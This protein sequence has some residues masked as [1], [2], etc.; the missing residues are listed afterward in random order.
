MSIRETIAGIELVDNH[1]HPVEELS[2]E[3]ITREFPTLFTEGGHAPADAR[4][5]VAYR[6]ALGLLGEYLDGGTEAELLA[7]RADVELTSYSRRVIGDTGTGV[8]LAD[9]GYPETSPAEFRSY[10]DAEVHPLLRLEPVIE[11]LVPRHERLGELVAAFESR[12]ED[13]LAGEYVG[14]KSIVAYRT[15]LDI[16]PPAAAE[17]AA[18]E[19]YD[20]FRAGFDGRVEHAGVI[21]HCLNRAA[22]LAADHGVPVQLHTGFGDSDAHP[23]FV[24][25]SYLYEFLGAHPGTDTVLLHGG[26]PYVRTAGYVTSTFPNAH[27]DLSLANPFVAHGVEPMLR[28]ALETVPATRLLYGSDAFSAP[29]IY[30]LAAERI[31]TD[32]PAVL[33]SLVDRGFYTEGYA[34]EV[35]R[36]VLRENAVELYGL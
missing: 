30:A 3:A 22:D 21:D 36:M 11:E 32:L 27:L 31:R 13:A 24:D 14:L 23:R 18:S 6:R 16:D 19:G 7:A 2:S 25:P 26:Y 8:I 5:T 33:E 29:E 15:G 9:D 34:E 17:T 28:Q 20:A 35:A 4:H 10:T 1:A 12:I